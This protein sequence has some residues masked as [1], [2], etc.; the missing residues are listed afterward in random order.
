MASL[1]T[2]GFFGVGVINLKTSHNY[3]TLF[4]TAHILGAD[5]IFLIGTRFK[6]QAS[7]TSYAHKNLPVFLYKDFEDFQAHRPYGGELV[8]I[9]M[10]E[11]A[12]PLH[13]FEHPKQACYLLGAED[14]GIPPSVL[15]KAQHVVKLEGEMSLNVAVAGS[16]VIYDRHIKLHCF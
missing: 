12:I 6:P 3:G 14:S 15:E 2:S 1:L 7:D 11:T 13:K 5:F 8:A 10:M 9:E 4:R 16:I